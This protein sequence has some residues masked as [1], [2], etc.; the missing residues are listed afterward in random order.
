MD[1]IS[2]SLVLCSEHMTELQQR[3][4]PSNL[5]EIQRKEFPG[6]FYTKVQNMQIVICSI[7]YL[8]L[9]LTI[10]YDLEQIYNLS[11]D[12]S[13][14]E[15][16]ELLSLASGPNFLVKSY[17]AGVI[18]GVR[19]VAYNRDCKRKTQNSGILV[20]GTDN[21][22]FYGQLE[23]IID[24]SYLNNLNVTLFKC[25]WY[26]VDPKKK[27][28]KTSQNITSIAINSEWYKDD[29][30]ILA[31]QAKQVFYVDDLLN[32][33]NWK[34]VNEL[35]YRAGWDI[36]D[37]DDKTDHEQVPVLQDDIS[38]NFVL[39]VDLGP[40]EFINL[41]NDNDDD[42]DFVETVQQSQRG[43]PHT[44]TVHDDFIDDSEQLEDETL[45]EYDE[46]EGAEED[47]TEDEMDINNVYS[48]SESE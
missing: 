33:P 14:V 24:L 25:K 37:T 2:E 40:L 38:S 41:T 45:E 46:E 42:D 23:E 5:I 4:G 13:L 21:N 6:W 29:P 19:F 18:N 32:G 12:G 3:D 39:T 7:L 16:D 1:N 8:N 10:F 20:A 31:D 44:P 26:D 35:N 30:F 17:S 36:A 43:H 34:I 27:R 15:D 47:E 9:S 28:I 48:D 11:K 22:T